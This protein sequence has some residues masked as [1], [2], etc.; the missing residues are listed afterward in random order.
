MKPILLIVPLACLLIACKSK[1]ADKVETISKPLVDVQQ[2]VGIGRIEPENEIIQLSAEVGGIVQKIYK[3]ENERVQA[4]DIIFEL[5]HTIEDA[6]TSQ[7]KSAV[8]IQEAQI[9]V[10][11]SAIKELQIKYANSNV[12]LQRLK[13]LLAKGAETQQVV[14]NATAEMQSFQANIQKLQATVQVSKM[15]WKE[16]KAEVAVAEAKSKQKFITAPVNGILLELNIQIG[17]SIDS[18]QIIA[19][20]NPGGKTIAVCE[21]D[22]LFA[23]KIQIGQ[24]AVI[25]NFG[26]IDTLSTGKVYFAESFL[27]K[28]S[29]FTDQAGEKED[30]RVRKIKIVLDK[31]TTILLNSRIEC[32]VFISKNNQ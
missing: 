16:T 11:E 30:R 19:Q 5:K 20:L 29:L 27:K 4:G 14:D 8:A 13:N 3:N 2:V 17:N 18:K 12:S 21:I 15:K 22:E 31:P 10:D 7:L 24:A 9:K 26:A 6:N 1:E 32:V 23:N 28:K 25:R